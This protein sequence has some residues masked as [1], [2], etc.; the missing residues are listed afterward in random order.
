MIL[1][2]EISRIIKINIYIVNCFDLKYLF[3]SD[4]NFRDKLAFVLAL[5]IKI[6]NI[7][8]YNYIFRFTFKD[9]S[10]YFI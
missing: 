5:Y 8:I 6:I 3:L 1:L 7:L 9:Y 4:C 10:F 2:L